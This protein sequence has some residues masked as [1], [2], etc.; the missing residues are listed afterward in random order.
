MSRL[1]RDPVVAPVD[2]FTH[3]GEGVARIDGKAV[4][5]PGALPG[6]RVRV[7]VV[8]DRK[9]W[10]RARLVEV[11]EAAP[12]RVE[13]PCPYVPDCGGCDLQHVS[14]RGQLALKTRVVREQ[15]QR[16]GSFDDP[17][18]AACVAV[19][20]ALGYRSSARMH[21]DDDGRL[22]YHR[23]GTNEVVPIDACAIL[24]D[25]TQAVRD[26]VGDDSGA[27][28][29][30]FR[31][32]SHGDRATVLTAGRDPLATDGIPEDVQVGLKS[33]IGDDVDP[34]PG[35]GGDDAV[36]ARGRGVVTERVGDFDYDVDLDGFFQGSAAGASALVEAV[37]DD[38]AHVGDGVA[39]L[40]V[41]D[42]Y[43]GVGLFT[44]PLADAGAT[45]TAVEVDERAVD[46]LVVNADRAAVA[47]RVDAGADDVAEFV[48]R[49]QP[50][51]PDIVVLDPPRTGA[52]SG[53]VEAIADFDPAMVVYV[54]CDPA[55]L[56]RDARSLADTGYRLEA[57][58]PFD[59][60][61]MTHHV[62]VVARFV[63]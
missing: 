55:A 37:M 29:A 50:D 18:V 41:W 30:R 40:E 56:A 5:V 63:R 38:V 3:G 10:A 4:F 1:S 8:D 33:A 39:G 35:V 15:L 6:E 17:P 61:P 9:R 45:V 48:T 43:A 12:E 52:G 13:P 57:A 19:G 36:V 53:V 16:I 44:L 51:L 49:P 42:L 27:I 7:A 11:L 28:G 47:D 25:A 31:T 24:D 21:A 14:V 23:A 20:P 54:A 46:L 58:R 32:S 62:E 60:F 59:L 2:G 22:G 26:A 34:S